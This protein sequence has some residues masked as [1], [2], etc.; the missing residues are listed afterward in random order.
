MIRRIAK[1]GFIS[2]SPITYQIVNLE[3]I[4]GLKD[5]AITPELLWQKGIVASRNKRVKILARGEVRAAFKIRAHAFSRS[6][7]E[8]IIKAGGTIEVIDAISAG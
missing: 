8:K 5:V 3:Q 2:K 4:A 7:R 1:R 6:A